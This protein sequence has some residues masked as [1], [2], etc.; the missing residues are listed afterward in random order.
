MISPT[1]DWTWAFK[2]QAEAFVDNLVSN[3]SSLASGNDSLEDLRFIET[4][5][6]KIASN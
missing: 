4:V 3:S 2:R 1:P 5:W 6:K